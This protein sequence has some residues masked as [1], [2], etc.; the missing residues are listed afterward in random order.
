[1]WLVFAGQRF[2]SKTL[3]TSL[4]ATILFPDHYTPPPASGDSDDPFC[5]GLNAYADVS[6]CV[7]VRTDVSVC[8]RA[9]ICLCVNS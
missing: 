1:M 4:Q 5:V 3:E 2:P 8:V 7:C 6:M 9:Y